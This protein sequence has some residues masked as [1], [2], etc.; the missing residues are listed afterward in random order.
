[1]YGYGYHIFV[2]ARAR[3][4]AAARWHRPDSCPKEMS[5]WLPA[6]VALFTEQKQAVRT[7][8]WCLQLSPGHPTVKTAP[9]SSAAAA[10]VDPL[11]AASIHP[12]VA[13]LHEQLIADRRLLHV[14]AELSFEEDFTGNFVAERLRELGLQPTVGMGRAPEAFTGAGDNYHRRE[15]GT[16]VVCDI[17]GGAGTDGP[18]IALRADMDALP[19]LETAGSAADLGGCES[20]AP[21]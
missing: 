4:A 11:A 13:A 5:R 7:M 17:E 10:A 16:G 3:A 18:C 8:P 9:T 1:M 14:N 6:P 15:V 21:L 2:A 19:I 12:Q 20:A